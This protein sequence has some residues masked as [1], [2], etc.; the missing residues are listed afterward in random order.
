MP[1]RRAIASYFKAMMPLA[2]FRETEKKIFFHNRL[3][4][5]PAAQGGKKAPFA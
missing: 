4:P 5:A 1:V 3:D 2:P